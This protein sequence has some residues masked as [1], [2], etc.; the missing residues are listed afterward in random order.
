MYWVFGGGQALVASVVLSF[1]FNEVERGE[2]EGSLSLDSVHRS[3]GMLGEGYP[4][5]MTEQKMPQL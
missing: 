5:L 2:N 1:R 4:D 3:R